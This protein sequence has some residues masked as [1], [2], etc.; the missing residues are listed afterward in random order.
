MMAYAGFML[1]PSLI[2]INCR[3]GYYISGSS[4]VS[5]DFGVAKNAGVTS[6]NLG[7]S[8]YVR[9]N[10]LVSG[11]G[12]LLT[13]GNGNTT[14]SLK[15]SVGISKINKNQTSSLDIFLDGN[16]GLTKGSL[17]TIGLS[18]GKSIYFGKRK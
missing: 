16:A 3:I 11:A 17:T 18:I 8:G 10:S 12:L 2:N 15:I 9:K 14:L 13:S 1:A 6:V 7:L 4:N 5:F